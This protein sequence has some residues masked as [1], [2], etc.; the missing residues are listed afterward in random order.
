MTTIEFA[1][2]IR[3]MSL[4]MV[5]NANASHIGSAFSIADILAVLYNDYLNVDSHN[6]NDMERDRFILSKG[7]ACVSVYA[8]LCLKGI[9]NENELETYAKDNSKLMSHI[10]H[11]VSGVEFSTGSLGHGL[12]F[13]VGKALAMKVQNNNSKVIVVLG[14]GEMQ[15]G[16][17]W[18][19]IMFASHH[20][21]DNLTI[22]IDLNNLQS[23][24]TVDETLS[25]QPL[26]NKLISFNWWVKEIDGHDYSQI[27]N[28]F[29]Q[30]SNSPKC[31][32]AHTTKGKG[33]DFME[34]EVKWH[35]KAPNKLE[36][37]DGL[38]QIYEKYLC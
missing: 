30:N 29:E 11:K 32:I 24:T 15:E 16:S 38:K 3:Q 21:L 7:H 20:K 33:I 4:K 2:R 1:G 31:I 36:L 27:L 26:Q 25:I 37:E 22:V 9:I 5:H 13:A 34:N 14:D 12:P 23:L 6:Y 18:E 35:Y 28:A 8:A 19:A 17:N 10:S